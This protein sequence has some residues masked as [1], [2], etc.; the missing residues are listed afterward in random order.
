VSRETITS[1]CGDFNVTSG[2]YDKRGGQRGEWHYEIEDRPGY[3]VDGLVLEFSEAYA[4][5][6][7]RLE[8]IIATIGGRWELQ[9]DLAKI[10]A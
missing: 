9:L 3:F 6:A 5:H 4:R 8:P 2:Y 1:S 7:G 10:E